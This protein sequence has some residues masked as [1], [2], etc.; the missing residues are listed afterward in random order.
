MVSMGLVADTLLGVDAA[1]VVQRIGTAVTRVKPGD[2]IAAF[3][4]Y[5]NLVH[6]DEGLV[7]ILP[8]TMSIEEGASL[9]TIVA[10]AYQSLVEIAH[11]GKGETVL[12][13]SA[14][15]GTSSLPLTNWPELY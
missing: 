4:G 3:G 2:H 8:P 12:I 15:G 5:A 9:P 10:T 6:I 1:G 7:E 11:L 14:A 13:H